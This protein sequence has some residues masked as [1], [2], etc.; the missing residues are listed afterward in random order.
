VRYI[1]R[2]KR[3]GIERAHEEKTNFGQGD[4][5]WDIINWF[6]GKLL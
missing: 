1:R 5:E 3:K 6:F 4:A 2:R